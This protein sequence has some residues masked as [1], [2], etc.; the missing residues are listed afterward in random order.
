MCARDFNRLK[1]G[2][3]HGCRPKSCASNGCSGGAVCCGL[4]NRGGFC[5]AP[6]VR[7]ELIV[8][9]NRLKFYVHQPFG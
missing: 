5:G 1:S 8:N 9:F 4:A 7:M 2:H 3:L 6:V